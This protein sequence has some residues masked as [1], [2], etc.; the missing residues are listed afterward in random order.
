MENN[1]KK[2]YA[3]SVKK[4][5][6]LDSVLINNDVVDDDDVEHEKLDFLSCL[7]Q[8][9]FAISIRQIIVNVI[10]MRDI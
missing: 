7:I 4:W 2:I 3:N 5:I 6:Q 1:K 8:D 9:I 10:F